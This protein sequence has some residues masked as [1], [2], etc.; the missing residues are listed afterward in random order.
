MLTLKNK[1]IA[2]LVLF[3]ISFGVYCFSLSH[4][5]VWDD[6]QVIEKSYTN[7]EAAGVGEHFFPKKVSNSK[8]RY[9]RP[10]L[11]LSY[12][13]DRVVWGGSPFGYHLSNLLF[14]SLAVVSFYFLCL[15]FFSYALPGLKDYASFFSAFLFALFPM[16]VESVAWVS[17]RT[18]LLAGLFFFLAFSAHMRISSAKGKLFFVFL[19]LS[20]AGYYLSLLSKEVAIAFPLVALMF[21]LA[22]G[23]FRRNQLYVYLAYAAL[24]AL[25]LFFRSRGFISVTDVIPSAAIIASPDIGAA[26]KPEA[27]G[28]PIWEFLTTLTKIYYF[29]IYKLLF[30][31][32]FNAFIASLPSGLVYHTF[33][34]FVVGIAG[35]ATIWALFKRKLYI[36][37][38][39]LWVLFTIGPSALIVFFGVSATA[40]AERYLYIPSAGYCILL[41]FGIVKFFKGRLKPMSISVI[42]LG[43]VFLPFIFFRQ[44]DWQSNLSLWQDTVAKSSAALPHVNLGYALRGVGMDEEAKGQFLIALH[45]ESGDS[46]RGRAITSN[47][48]GLIYLD[49][50]DLDKAEFA[51]EKA[52]KLDPSYGRTYHHLG[53]VYFIRG[54]ESGLDSDFKTARKHLRK[55]LRAY[56]NY[57]LAQL[58]MA[59][60][61]FELGEYEK[62][63]IMAGRALQSGLPPGSLRHEA[64]KFWNV[65]NEAGEDNPKKNASE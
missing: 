2:A 36:S 25:Y 50:D 35:L 57:G 3:V 11:M 31:F 46:K 20:A 34:F 64:E 18:D 59:K 12:F 58:L 45:P 14:N 22:R 52:A 38:A 47:N 29:Y 23:E 5:F 62:A 63:R 51:F 24:T 21:D 27:G 43:L 41:V 10:V 1:L 49:E 60:V 44:L 65:D 55:A 56:R 26:A 15:V 9:W 33:A 19:I 42:A 30:P 28:L 8:S 32:G 40:V 4:D 7:F 17:G 48:L 16:H 61:Q 39:V 53:L 13:M 6:T 37:F 54:S